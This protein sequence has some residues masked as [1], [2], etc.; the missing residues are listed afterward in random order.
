MIVLI[1]YGFYKGCI[2]FFA[3]ANSK[4]QKVRKARSRLQSRAVLKWIELVDGIEDKYSSQ[5]L[6]LEVDIVT[7]NTHF[8][9]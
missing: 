5:E 2:Q 9:H 7:I 8:H 4:E 3:T 6:K 1:Q